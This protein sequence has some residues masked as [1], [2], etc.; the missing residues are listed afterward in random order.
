MVKITW[1]D[2]YFTLSPKPLLWEFDLFH[3]F[4]WA[5]TLRIHPLQQENVY[6]QLDISLSTCL[7][8]TIPIVWIITWLL[9]SLMFH[10]LLFLCGE[11][12][13]NLQIPRKNYKK[14]LMKILFSLKNFCRKTIDRK[15]P[16]GWFKSQVASLWI[17][18]QKQGFFYYRNYLW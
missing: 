10:M 6:W 3:I 4:L 1:H 16:I 2:K 15:S 8:V 11:K 9:T 7:P 18:T 12:Q 5:F 13:N 17:N 14:L